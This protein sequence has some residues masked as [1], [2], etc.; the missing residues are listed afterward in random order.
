MRLKILDFYRKVE[1]ANP[2]ASELRDPTFFILTN[3]NGKAHELVLNLKGT[4]PYGALAGMSC[5]EEEAYKNFGIIT[6]FL[7]DECGDRVRV[8]WGL[9]KKEFSALIF[10]LYKI[11]VNN[12]SYYGWFKKKLLILLGYLKF[13]SGKG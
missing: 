1:E 8:S 5:F 6:N 4:F 13:L 2:F 9:S 3:R 11:L 7:L 10:E 12:H